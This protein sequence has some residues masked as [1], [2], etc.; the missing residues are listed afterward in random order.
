MTIRSSIPA[1]NLNEAWS[2]FQ[3]CA[4]EAP[5]GI[6]EQAK[7]IAKRIDDT[8]RELFTSLRDMGMKADACDRIREVEAV[9]YGYVKDSNPGASV[10][11]TA[12]GFGASLDDPV[13]RARVLAQA[14]NDRDEIARTGARAAG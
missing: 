9:I 1:R 10:F 8:A 6:Y 7:A 14:T 12:E 4:E 5:A 2:N 13:L 11:T 3:R